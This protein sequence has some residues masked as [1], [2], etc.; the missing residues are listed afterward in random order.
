MFSIT[1]VTHHAHFIAQDPADPSTFPPP[2]SSTMQ[3]TTSS[4]NYQHSANSQGFL[5]QSRPEQYNGV[6]EI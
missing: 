4:I 5:Q 2:L 6:P 3:T 1:F